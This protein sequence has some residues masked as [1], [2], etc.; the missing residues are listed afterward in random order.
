MT[1]GLYDGR[2]IWLYDSRKIGQE[3]NTTEGLYDEKLCDGTVI[4]RKG[5]RTV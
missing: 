4:C 1:K 2:L 3:D 5:G